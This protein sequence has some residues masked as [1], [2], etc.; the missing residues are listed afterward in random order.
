VTRRWWIL[1][2]VGVALF[3]AAVV[4]RPW[5]EGNDGWPRNVIEEPGL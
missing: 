4:V 2:A 1:V 3:V 5:T